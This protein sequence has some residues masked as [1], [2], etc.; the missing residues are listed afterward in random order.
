M[1]K[2]KYDKVKETSI[3]DKI[4]LQHK[5]SYNYALEQTLKELSQ[6]VESL[7]H[8]LNSLQSRSGNQLPF[9]SINYGTC[10]LKEGQ[11]IIDALLDGQMNGTGPDHRTS[12]FPCAIFQYYKKINGTPGTPNYYL[13]RKALKS[14]AKR[15]YPNFANCDW[16]LQTKGQKFDREE[17]QA[18]IDILYKTEPDLYSKLV[19]W[20]ENHP[21]ESNMMS[22]H[23]TDNLIFTDDW[24]DQK[25]HE[26]MSTMGK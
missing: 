18:A 11:Y 14:C 1:I 20:L 21:Y 3:E 8:N 17:K 26:I 6:G 19:A 24:T 9:S 5:E 16:S 25:P 15:I 13:Y 7:F 2:T 22:I 12:I 4:W 23:V 10:T